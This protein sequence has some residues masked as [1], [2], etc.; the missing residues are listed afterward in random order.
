MANKLTLMILMKSSF[1]FTLLFVSILGHAQQKN[2]SLD[3]TRNSSKTEKIA[4][5]NFFENGVSPT[6]YRLFYPEL[7]QSGYK[8]MIFQTEGMDGINYF[9]SRLEDKNADGKLDV[10]QR[11]K[12][13]LTEN[14][15]FPST[16]PRP[17]IRIEIDKDFSSKLVRDTTLIQDGLDQKFYEDASG[18]YFYN[19]YSGD[20]TVINQIGITDWKG[21]LS[22]NG[23]QENIDYATDGTYVE[24]MPRIYRKKNGKIEDITSTH[25]K[26]SNRILSTRARYPWDQSLG[27][28]DFDGD[29]DTDVLTTAIHQS[30]TLLSGLPEY[31]SRQRNAFYFYQNDGKG[32]LNGEIY[33]FSVPGGYNWLIPEATM[34]YPTQMDEDPALEIISELWI[35]TVGDQNHVPKRNLGYFNL[36]HSEKKLEFT[37]LI[38]GKDYLLDA[39]WNIFPRLFLPM[40]FL[41][42]QK[43]LILYL[44]T[45]PGGS[46]AKEYTGVNLDSSTGSDFTKGVVQQYFRMYEKV[47]EGNIY[48]LVDVTNQ[49]FFD[50]EYQTLSLDNNGTIHLIDVDG[51][52]KLDIFPQLGATPYPVV[53][54]LNKF[55]KYPTWNG[56][57]NSLYY[58]KQTDNKKFKLTDLA[59]V[60]G[61][62]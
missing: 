12:E 56:K 7:N 5:A 27:V 43:D 33:D 11:I 47:K 37:S 8:M 13:Y 35:D 58:F 51:D 31:E 38:A 18:E 23:Y 52:G 20:P 21:Y 6:T 40:N 45:S 28:G 54:G 36:N 61:F 25:L 57:T 39:S 2:S 60:K 14:W 34:Q 26:F 1:I 9:G 29:G 30:T 22:K 42:P 15:D 50:G 16:N 41:N 55:L 46:P 48:K 3:S 32:V 62:Y 59:E 10:V 19:F 53:G 49:Y 4:N 24:F 17:F 44:F